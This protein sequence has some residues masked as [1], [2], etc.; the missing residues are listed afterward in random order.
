PGPINGPL[1]Q[2]GATKQKE[3]PMARR[4]SPNHPRPVYLC[5]S[6]T[7]TGLVRFLAENASTQCF[8]DWH[9]QSAVLQCPVGEFVRQLQLGLPR[10]VHHVVVARV[11]VGADGFV[12]EAE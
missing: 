8:A 11:V 3:A 12:A 10:A 2:E 4:R 5:K 1:T 7:R 6:E 9:R